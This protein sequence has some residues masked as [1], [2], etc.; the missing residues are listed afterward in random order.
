[1]T[2]RYLAV[3]YDDGAIAI[4]LNNAAIPATHHVVAVAVADVADAELF[5]EPRLVAV[6]DTGVPTDEPTPH[7]ADI[8]QAH[9]WTVVVNGDAAP[10]AT[11]REVTPADP[12]A[13]LSP[14]TYLNGKPEPC[15]LT[16]RS[17]L[18]DG[19]GF[20]EALDR[21]IV[22]AC[23][24]I[25]DPSVYNVSAY[26]VHEQVSIAAQTAARNRAEASGVT[27]LN[28]LAEPL[29]Q[30]VLAAACDA[31]E[32]AADD[33]ARRTFCRTCDAHATGRSDNKP[34]CSTTGH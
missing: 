8:L 16:G 29:A 6:I 34:T 1:M 18:M 2:T 11:Q 31:I 13:V 28:Q 5:P 4:D 17:A 20:A 7:L 22:S 3:A 30:H 15:Y 27:D 12:A 25:G 14:V 23:S 9:G 21:A 33:I 26:D 19:Q 10:D 32:D 24:M